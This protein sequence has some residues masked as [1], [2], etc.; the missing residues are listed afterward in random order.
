MRLL[1]GYKLLK[2]SVGAGEGQRGKKSK[3]LGK[4]SSFRDV[5]GKPLSDV[6]GRG[7]KAANRSGIGTKE[8]VSWFEEI[9][10]L[11]GMGFGAEGK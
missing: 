4:V 7:G 9:S 8:G 10:S 3:L 6:R 2:K 11:Q 5:E 1:R